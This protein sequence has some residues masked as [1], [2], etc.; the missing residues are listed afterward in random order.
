MPLLPNR[1]F[2]H[3]VPWATTL[4]FCH[5]L[6]IDTQLFLKTNYGIH[7][8][9]KLLATPPYEPYQSQFSFEVQNKTVHYVVT[10]VPEIVNR[11]NP[12]EYIAQ[13]VRRVFINIASGIV[14]DSS[15]EEYWE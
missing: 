15:D 4:V 12:Q 5:E 1:N 3:K 14:E 8:Q 10:L 6:I 9:V 2:W 13:K 7:T 11:N